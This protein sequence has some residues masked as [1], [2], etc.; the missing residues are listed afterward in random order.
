M[1]GWC[2]AMSL[3]QNPT[4]LDIQAAIRDLENRPSVTLLQ[5]N[6]EAEALS[7]SAANPGSVVW[8]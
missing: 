1:L 2:D 5:A 7:L 6:S 4:Q 3:P 8:W